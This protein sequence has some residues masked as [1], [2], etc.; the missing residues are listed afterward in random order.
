MH[1]LSPNLQTPGYLVSRVNSRS[2]KKLTIIYKPSLQLI[3][4]YEWT[5]DYLNPHKSVWIYK[6]TT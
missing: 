2:P 3:G 1:Q 6:N 4:I 5:L